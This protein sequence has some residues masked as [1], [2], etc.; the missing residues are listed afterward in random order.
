MLHFGL[1]VCVIGLVFG[2]IQYTQ[3]KALPVHP[4]MSD[5]SDTIW[6][7]CKTYL[8]QQG[9]FLVV[10]WVLIGACMVYYFGGLQHKSFGNRGRSCW[11]LDPRHPRLLRRGLVRHP[12]QHAGQLAL[13]V[14]R[15]AGHAAGGRWPSR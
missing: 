8:F 11:P 7:T 13:G 2:L 10:L 9:K 6:E 1:V 15:A 12:H 14:R 5:V 3:I 4:W